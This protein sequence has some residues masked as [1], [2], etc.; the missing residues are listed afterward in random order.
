MTKSSRIVG[1]R[2]GGTSPSGISIPGEGAALDVLIE[3]ARALF[4]AGDFVDAGAVAAR[5]APFVHAKF[6][7]IGG[8]PRRPRRKGRRAEPSLFPFDRELN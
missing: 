7:T 2:P 6:A 4:A 3:A 1:T 5:A 8:A